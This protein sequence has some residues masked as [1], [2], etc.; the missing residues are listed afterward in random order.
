MVS[1]VEPKIKKAA[2]PT[3]FLISKFFSFYLAF[4]LFYLD[5]NSKT[6]TELRYQ[7]KIYKLE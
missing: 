1:L 3:Y 6:N 7:N 2:N 5:F 4:K